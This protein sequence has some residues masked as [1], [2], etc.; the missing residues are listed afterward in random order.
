LVALETIH[1]E[2]YSLLNETLGLENFAEFLEDES[3]MA[4]IENLMACK[5]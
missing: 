1:A 3:T 5:R 2:A 4:K